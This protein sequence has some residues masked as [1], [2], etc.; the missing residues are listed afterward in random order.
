MLHFPGGNPGLLGFAA[1]RGTRRN[2]KDTRIGIEAQ[3][4]N[5]RLIEPAVN[6]KDFLRSLGLFKNVLIAFEARSEPE[7]VDLPHFL[8]LSGLS[9][10]LFFVASMHDLQL[11]VD[12]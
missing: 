8:A 11:S 12:D 3:G 2:N 4:S 7:L 10:D 6:P 9:G 1:C 5:Q